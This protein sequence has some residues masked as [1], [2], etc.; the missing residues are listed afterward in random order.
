[1]YIINLQRVRIFNATISSGI[2]LK[3]FGTNG[4]QVNVFFEKW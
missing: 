2:F 4:T 3:T 1:M